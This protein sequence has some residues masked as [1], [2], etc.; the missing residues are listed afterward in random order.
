MTAGAGRRLAGRR[1]FE[2]HI[3]Q[4]DPRARKEDDRRRHRRAGQ[5]WYEIAWTGMESHAGTTPWK[6]GATRRRRGRADRGGRAIGNRP[7][8]RSTIGVIESLPQSRN[9][10][11]AA[12]S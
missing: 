5:R 10:I 6:E 9:T 2:A 8:G 12:C 3:E 7:N 4:A 11:P 1:F